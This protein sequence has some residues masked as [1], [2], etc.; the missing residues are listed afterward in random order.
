[1]KRLEGK[2]AVITGGNSGVGEAT[3]LLFA[4]E[5]A[6]VVIS[7]RRIDNLLKVEEK[8]KAIGGEV[9]TVRC[10]ISNDDD[11]NNLIHEAI[12]KFGK[13]DC[14]VNNAGV[15]DTSIKGIDKYLDDDFDKVVAINQ[16]GTMQVMRAALNHM[17]SGSSIVNVASVA[18]VNGGGGAVYVSTKAALIG[19]TKH[20]ALV[21]AS[22]KIR[23]NAVCP[24][25]IVTPMTMQMD[26]KALD[27][28]VMGAMQKHGDLTVQPCM[29]IDVARIILF[30][31]SD[32]S[33]P[34]TGQILVSDFGANL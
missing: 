24:G 32:E 15:L 26:P 4:E 1:M 6:K 14:L 16:K 9:L 17:E 18:G 7:A 28:S 19:L 22:N 21:N 20:V 34:L 8:I 2:V 10:D 29:A 13:I 33:K 27:M 23:C 12:H 11:C 3:A 5:G 30:L 25:T 31:A